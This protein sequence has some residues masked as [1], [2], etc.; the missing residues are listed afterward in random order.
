MA[1]AMQLNHFT[2]LGI[3]IV[4]LSGRMVNTHSA[5]LR[6]KIIACING[7]TGRLIVDMRGVTFVDA[8]GL[9]VLVSAMKAVDAINGRFALSGLQPPVLSL[10]ELTRLHH[11]FEVFFT[12]EAATESLN[13]P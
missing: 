11:I 1:A 2:R 7:G 12:L 9:S 10:L 13:L 3:D 5:E 6:P 8:S 4:E